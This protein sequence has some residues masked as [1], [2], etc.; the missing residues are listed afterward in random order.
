MAFLKIINISKLWIISSNKD[1]NWKKLSNIVYL[2]IF[3]VPKI[4]ID[5][6]KNNNANKNNINVNKKA[7]YK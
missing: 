7:N 6:L 2:E 5:L 1:Y 4:I 3:L